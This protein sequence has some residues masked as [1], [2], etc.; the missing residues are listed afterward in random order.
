MLEL[1]PDCSSPLE[2]NETGELVY[3]NNPDCPCR[4]RGKILNY[5]KKMDIANISYATIADFY[6]AGY[7]KKI[8]DL[9]TL[10]KHYN[11]LVSIT[12][13]GE[14]KV[15]NILDEIEK[16]KEVI[17]SV[18][19]GSIG[20]ESISTK[21]F[22][23]ILEYLTMAEIISYAND[24]VV[25]VFTSIPGI[26]EKTAMKIISGINENMHTINK[27]LE[28]LTILNEPRNSFDFTVAFSKVR[29][30]E[31]ANW[32]NENGGLAT[33]DL[34]KEANLLVVPN[35]QVTSS[36]IEKAHKYG[37]PIVSVYDA[38]DYITKNLL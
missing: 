11:R 10:D 31:L 16:R 38:K 17:P 30:E 19:L 1:C 35:L 3:C 18:F 4:V 23:K 26:K 13:Y 28:Y 7:L 8:E 14:V 20:I 37:I 33:D 36:K 32:I 12:G 21:T 25:G 34:T 9:Y 24:E 6:E 5:C 22:K 27:L 15:S 29:D 2:I